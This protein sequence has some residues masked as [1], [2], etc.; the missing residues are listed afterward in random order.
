M[1]VCDKKKIDGLAVNRKEFLA[2]CCGNVIPAK[3]GI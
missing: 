1:L 2:A 3:A